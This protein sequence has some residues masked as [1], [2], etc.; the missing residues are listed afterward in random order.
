MTQIHEQLKAIRNDPMTPP[1]FFSLEE[2]A[3]LLLHKG[4]VYV[5]DYRE[6][7]LAVL[8]ALHDHLLVGHPGIH[9]TIC[10]ITWKYYWPG[11]TRTVKSYV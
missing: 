3:T 7:R 1:T 4:Q 11:L 2:D 10:H 8:W 9:K 5:P 6:V